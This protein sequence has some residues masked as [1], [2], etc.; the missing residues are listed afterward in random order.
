M[1]GRNNG[2]YAT[3]I[4]EEKLQLLTVTWWRG[5]WEKQWEICYLHLGGE[6]TV[7]DSNVV[8]GW[9]GET[10]GNM[11]PSSWRRNYSY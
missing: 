4:L 1:A 10:M 6:T 7:I 2:K 11:L 9:L 3:F 8:E 5:G